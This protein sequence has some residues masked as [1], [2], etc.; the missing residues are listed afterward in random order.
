MEKRNRYILGDRQKVN[1]ISFEEIIIGTEANISQ[2]IT[3]ND[4]EVFDKFTGDYQAQN[5]DTIHAVGTVSK[6]RLVHGMLTASFI[7][8]MI[9]TQLPGKGSLWYEQELRF[10]APAVIGEKIR[11]YAKVKSKSLSQRIIT[12]ETIVFGEDGRKLVEGEA[13]VKV[14]KSNYREGQG[15]KTRKKGVVVITGASRGIGAA[16]AKELALNG[17]S[18]VVNY[19]QSTKLAEGV[20]KDIIAKKGKAAAFKADVADYDSVKKMVDFAY[21][22]FGI[23][24]GIINN[25]S[26]PIENLNFNQLSWDHIQRHIDVQIKGAFNLC[27]IVLPYFLAEQDGVIIN[28]ASTVVD[29]V[30]PLMW[31]PYCMAKSALISFSRS[32][33]VEYGLRG[34]RVNCISPGMTQ[35]DFIA[36]LPEKVKMVTR[37]QTPLRRLAIPEDIAG[38]AVFLFSDKARHITGE[39]IRVCGGI[40][41]G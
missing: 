40:I 18:I 33:A 3:T 5:I 1:G 17:Y 21:R 7:S 26:P 34:I 13:K 2:V 30:P 29:N 32:L 39:N 22:E 9:G 37:M 19:A 20:V 24:S 11:I 28:I 4:L 6:N 10:L 38:A 35:T 41:M 16:I 12:I 8:K 14:L 25:A 23:I 31:L 36:D 15:L 27:Q